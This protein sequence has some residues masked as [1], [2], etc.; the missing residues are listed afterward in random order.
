MLYRYSMLYV[1]RRSVLA[2]LLAVPLLIAAPAEAVEWLLSFEA[3]PGGDAAGYTERATQTTELVAEL[4]PPMLDAIGLDS[5]GIDVEIAP[6]GYRGKMNPSVLLHLDGEAADADRAARALGF[7]FAQESV[8]VWS[9]SGRDT[10]AV[11]VE[12]PNLTP[13]LAAYFFQSAA[14]VKPGLAG[15]FTAR[16]RELWFLNLRGADG[17]PFSGLADAEFES[18]LRQAA[19]TFGGTVR[20]TRVEARLVDADRQAPPALERLRARRADLLGG[21]QRR[22]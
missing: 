9:D 22:P 21:A 14:A 1:C 6:G 8:L 12:F 2:L 3:V 11:A 5:G 13:N 18:A 15:G 20:S 7:V 17:L 19:G 16:G 4:V 10:F